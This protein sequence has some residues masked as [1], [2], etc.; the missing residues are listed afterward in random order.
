MLGNRSFI[1]T[2]GQPKPPSTLTANSM[3]L[4][5]ILL[6]HEA[7]S[8]PLLHYLVAARAVSGISEVPFRAPSLFDLFCL[9]SAISQAAS[10]DAPVAVLAGLDEERLWL[11]RKTWCG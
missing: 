11:K 5:Y 10:T 6:S 9:H 8:A 3:R 2:P 7:I 4:E 1:V